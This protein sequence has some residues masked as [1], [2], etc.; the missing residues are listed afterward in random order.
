MV[1]T[2][3]KLDREWDEWIV[4]VYED[5]KRIGTYHTDD[6]QDAI[7]TAKYVESQDYFDAENE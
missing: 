6:K 3:I 4:S 1:T 7:D 5:G 2:K